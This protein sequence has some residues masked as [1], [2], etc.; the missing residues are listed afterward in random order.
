MSPDV[1]LIRRAAL[2]HRA[3][4]ADAHDPYLSSALSAWLE[5]YV[6][7][8][9]D[10]IDPEVVKIG[11]AIIDETCA[12]PLPA[13]P[14]GSVCGRLNDHDGHCGAPIANMPGLPSR[15]PQ[16]DRGGAS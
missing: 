8:Y 15:D 1:D 14:V 3:R 12:R 13:S 7:Q 5:R 11:R 2:I 16:M 9:P 10:E 6:D 4:A